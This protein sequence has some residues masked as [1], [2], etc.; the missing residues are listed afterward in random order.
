MCESTNLKVLNKICVIS[1]ILCFIIV[2]NA[3]PQVKQ[4][5]IIQE[6]NRQELVYYNAKHTQF[7]KQKMLD[8][9]LHY[10][11]KG[12]EHVKA[13][14]DY[15]SYFDN[16]YLL[17]F[18][19]QQT[20]QY[21]YGLELLLEGLRYYPICL[22]SIPDSLQK[23]VLNKVATIFS[24]VA[25]LYAAKKAVYT[26][27]DY[28]IK[29]L[30]LRK[31]IFGFTHV[32]TAHAYNALGISYQQVKNYDKALN[33]Y[34][35]A[36]NIYAQLPGRFSRFK[37]YPLG[38]LGNLYQRKKEYDL[39][40]KYLQKALKKSV[41]EAGVSST[42][43]AVSYMNIGD[44]YSEMGLY[45]LA[46]ENYN[47]A[48]KLRI[49]RLGKKH[50][51]VAGLYNKLGELYHKQ[52]KYGKA[53]K[54][55]Q[56]ALVS[57]HHAFN[58]TANV[59]ALPTSSDQ[60]Y[61]NSTLL[62]SFT[63][64]SVTL[65]KV[66]RSKNNLEQAYKTYEL[67][68]QL[69]DKMS[70]NLSRKSDGLRL[71]SKVASLYDNALQLCWKLSQYDATQQV[72]NPKE[73]KSQ[74]GNGTATGNKYNPYL[75]KAFYFAEKGKS[76]VL[77]KLATDA[78]ARIKSNIPEAVLNQ[79]RKL[80]GSILYYQRQLN[81]FQVKKALNKK[82]SVQK[83]S[84][85]NR[86]F[87]LRRKYDDLLRGLEQ[88]YPDYYDLKHNT[89]IATVADVQKRLDEKTALIE[90]VL[91]DK[92]LYSFVI[93]K[94]GF[95]VKQQAANRKKTEAEIKKW[96]Y[97]IKGGSD[98]NYLERGHRFF[99]QFIQPIEKHISS[100][101]HLL[102][103]PDGL[104]SNLPFEAF[105]TKPH[106]PNGKQHQYPYLIR[107]WGVTLYPSAS[108]ALLK[109][110]RRKATHTQEF[111]GFAPVFQTKY[112]TSG[113]F[114]RNLSALPYTKTEVENIHRLFTSLKRTSK[115]YTGEQVSER[116]IKN[117]TG[118][119]R[120]VHFATHGMLDDDTP[121]LA[122]YPDKVIDSAQANDGELSLEEI[123]NLKFK[124]DMVVLSSCQGG[125]GRNV[126]GEGILAIT[127]G[128]VYLGVPHIIYTLWS[129]NDKDAAELMIRFYKL[130]NQSKTY[131]E[132]LRLAKLS[133]LQDPK[134]AWPKWWA[135]FTMMS[136]MK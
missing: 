84:F 63:E 19:A 26:A 112:A 82:D 88:R 24:R 31:E 102:I 1:L 123:F 133:M 68:D 125:A 85:E 91:T 17:G 109:Q 53:L 114:R 121:I 38:N 59:Y 45:D 62:T 72:G 60:V 44:T 67:A 66:S 127:R 14:N 49:S 16:L 48:L 134:T 69:A 131:R 126:K 130:L 80:N 79:E 129:V 132:A 103:V 94:D 96:F 18:Y 107:R 20:Y 75:K 43:V 5:G 54:F 64:K 77:R 42:L 57:N 73:N 122:F 35:K 81:R 128:F 83:Q 2:G 10:L 89:Y 104:L 58:D 119:Y 65:E 98:D 4:W 37:R 47:K 61:S 11:V 116:M 113:I 9:A 100:K 23:S 33:C 105:I 87:D 99:K 101:K 15:V 27:L 135:G 95:W 115:I 111:M 78:S 110:Q 12:N 74:T 93:T 21:N 50:P 30:N 97:N 52:K 41:E 28:R 3:F 117:L 118:Y 13:L 7:A 32:Q 56:K 108:L 124:A 92:Q 39:A 8:S 71:T 22:V 106:P 6:V 34:K 46:L 29:Y 120:F 40:L 51:F 55:Y 25:I 90:Y 136:K 70:E 76:S 86:I 36:L